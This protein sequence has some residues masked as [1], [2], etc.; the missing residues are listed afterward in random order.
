M[1]AVASA[2]GPLAGRE[3]RHFVDVGEVLQVVALIM[4]SSAAHN[5]VNINLIGDGG[6]RVLLYVGLET[7]RMGS[8]LPPAV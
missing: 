3:H 8:D 6:C 4:P 5:D 1:L 2:P 7:G